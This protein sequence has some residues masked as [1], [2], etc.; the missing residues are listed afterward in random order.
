MTFGRSTLRF[1]SEAHACLTETW[2]RVQGRASIRADDLLAVRV[3]ARA[4]DCQRL[5]DLLAAQEVEIQRLTDRLADGEAEV[6][7]LVAELYGLDREAMQVVEE[8]LARF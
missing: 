2:L 6:D 7:T 8:F 5:L 3:P 4:E 1:P